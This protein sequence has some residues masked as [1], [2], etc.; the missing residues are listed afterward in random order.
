MDPLPS[1]PEAFPGLP[2]GGTR[3]RAIIL[4]MVAVLG[5]V[6]LFLVAA[7]TD[8]VG[9]RAL[10]RAARKIVAPGAQVTL[11]LAPSDHARKVEMCSVKGVRTPRAT[12]VVCRTVA[13]SVKAGVTQV[14]VTIPRD[15]PPGPVN[16]ISRPR[17]LDGKLLVRQ[18]TTERVAL[19][20]VRSA[21]GPPPS[22]HV[23]GP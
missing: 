1:G 22:G 10:V 18:P 8:H 5:V 9:T 23:L 20:V 16:I 11:N 21:A 19:T 13:K 17:G 14:R 7:Y 2:L 3:Q 15:F 4:V 6:A 12:I